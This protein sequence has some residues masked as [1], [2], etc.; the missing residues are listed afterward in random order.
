MPRINT[1][2]L[3][4]AHSP[5]PERAAWLETELRNQDLRAQAIQY[6]T[7]SQGLIETLYELARHI[8]VLFSAATVQNAGE[9]FVGARSKGRMPLPV[10]CDNHPEYA[11]L[12]DIARV[13][14]MGIDPVAD[15]A[16]LEELAK[17]IRDVR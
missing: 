16:Q 17:V 4:S 12:A 9:A 8:I 2:I 13:G 15:K 3:F 11:L 5:E 7:I 1:I 10:R 14:I 6:E